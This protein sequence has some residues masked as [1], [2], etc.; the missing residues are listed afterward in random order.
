MKVLVPIDASRYSTTTL[1]WASKSLDKELTRYY[2]LHVI[3]KSFP[4]VMAESQQ[5]EDA[6][7]T[8]KEAKWFLEARGCEVERAEYVLGSPVEAICRYADEIQV[9][10]VLLGSHGET[11]RFE[12]LL[13]SVCRGVLEQCQK[14]VFLFQDPLRQR[15]SR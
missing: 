15:I 12:E 5:V 10:E 1:E 13:G 9:D 3:P 6:V 2:L 8:L 7:R 4:E 14:P 11:P